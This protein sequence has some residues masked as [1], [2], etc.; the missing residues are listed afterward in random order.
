MFTREF[1]FTIAL[2]FAASSGIPGLLAK[3]RALW[4]QWVATLLMVVGCTF[5]LLGTVWSLNAPDERIILSLPTPIPSANFLLSA[6]V[7]SAFFLIPIFGLTFLGAIY[8]LDYWSASDHPED[9][10]RLRFFYGLITASMSIIVLAHNS[11]TFL[12]GWEVMAVSA[13]FLVGTQDT[14]ADAR[15]AA[16]LYFAA[17]HAATLT[18]FVMFALLNQVT[19]SYDLIPLSGDVV[20]PLMFSAI[21]LLALAG[22][23]LKAGLM[24][25]HFWLPSA[26]AT[27]P[28]HVSAV[29]SGV[30]IKT[31]IYGLV[32]VTWLLP[33]PPLW[34][35]ELLL[36][37]GA[38][39]AVLGVAFALGQHD[40]KRLLAYHSI[41]N[42][43]IIVIGLGLAMV[44]RSTGHE[45]WIV[46]GLSGCLLHVWNHALF[47]SLLFLSAG[48]VIHARGTR[49]IDHLGGLAKSM[50]WTSACFLLGAAA[51]C[52]LPP[53]NGFISEFMI[54]LGLFQT[55]GLHNEQGLPGIAFLVP[56]MALMGTLAVACFVK[57]F[58]VV[59]LGSDRSQHAHPAHEATWIMI[60]PMC[61]LAIGC[62]VI[63]LGSPLIAPWLDRTLAVWSHQ[64]NLPIGTLESAA[65]L[66]E[67]SVLS[68][69]LLVTLSVGGIL[70]GWRIRSQP[71][72]WTETWGCGYSAPTARMQYTA[73]SLAQMLVGILAW[74]LQPQVQRPTGLHYFPVKAKFESYV[75]E[76]VLERFIT[77]TVNGV[78]K[79]LYWFRLVQQGSIQIYLLYIFAILVVLLMFA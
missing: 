78:G 65:P 1:C 43:G 73:S 22:F 71:V 17:S 5:G 4:G 35:G 20:S 52:G 61:V 76:V 69:G 67:V 39:S 7:L 16:W 31:G 55:L 13:F 70:L 54:Y 30:M 29:M 64:P 41:E 60:G 19:G 74:P 59:F 49:E 63:G 53:L 58:G 33:I 66:A 42:I 18:L 72:T 51:I 56:V 21:F 9:G 44:G 34:H 27:A 23:G 8:S 47:K 11:V 75:P 79:I 57:V 77:P 62:I 48:C 50:P 28:S 32:R 38:I 68:I 2:L 6:D 10:K 46:L 24:P 15:A 36:T 3:P 12:I 25:L 40:L 26:H 37:L 45:L 14:Q